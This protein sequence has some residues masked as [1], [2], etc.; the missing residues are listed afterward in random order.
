M[1][2]A[3]VIGVD[4]GRVGGVSRHCAVRIGGEHVV[5]VVCSVAVPRGLVG[6]GPLGV[7]GVVMPWGLVGG[8]SCLV[9]LGLAV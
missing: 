3:V 5:W 2:F 4:R 7:S 1:R 6:G 9:V 8:A